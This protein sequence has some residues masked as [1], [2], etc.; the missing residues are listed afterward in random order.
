MH[1]LEMLK[2]MTPDECREVGEIFIWAAGRPRDATFTANIDLVL[3]KFA[4]PGDTDRAAAINAGRARVA[5][6]N[7][8]L[9]SDGMNHEKLLADE[10]AR[11]GDVRPVDVY[12]R[13]ICGGLA[14]SD[15]VHGLP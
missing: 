10:L 1:P 4:D 12:C 8:G 15:V 9:R 11:R 2:R 6:L 7:D 13:E 5:A 14:H 3:A